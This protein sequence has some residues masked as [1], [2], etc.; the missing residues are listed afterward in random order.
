MRSNPLALDTL[1]GQQFAAVFQSGREYPEKRLFMAVMMTAIA[2]FHDALGSPK[3][4]EGWAFQ[5]LVTW[6]FSRDRNWPFSFENLCE[7]LDLSPECV[8]HQLRALL[9]KQHIRVPAEDKDN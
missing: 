4:R 1:A 5:E 8:R 3:R 2:E 9:R 7:H 6:F